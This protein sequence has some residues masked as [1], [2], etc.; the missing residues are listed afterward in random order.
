MTAIIVGNGGHCA[1]KCLRNKFAFIAE[2]LFGPG[3][4]D[5]GQGWFEEDELSRRTYQT[6]RGSSPGWLGWRWDRHKNPVITI[7]IDK[8]TFGPGFV[9]TGQGRSEVDKQSDTISIDKLSFQ[10]G[11]CRNW[12]AWDGG[13]IK[14]NNYLGLQ[15]IHNTNWKQVVDC[16]VL[17]LVC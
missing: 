2:K 14:Q 7:I 10:G 6:G 8:Q 11:V 4:G 12:S 5:T 15:S 13:G 17:L 9:E 16:V 3:F 1:N